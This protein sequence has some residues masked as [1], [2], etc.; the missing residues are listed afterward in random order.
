MIQ[1]HL[2]REKTIELGSFY[3]PGSLVN[4]AY[5]MLESKEAIKRDTIILDTSCGYGDFFL[6]NKGYRY[7]GSDID[8]QAL[9]KIGYGIKTFHRNALTNVCRSSYGIRE[10]DDLIIIGNPPYNDKSS[11]VG[12]G[13]KGKIYGVDDDLK[14]RD[15][16]ISF[17]RSYE[18]LSPSYVC[19][20]H[21]LSYLIKESNFKALKKFK[22][23]YTLIDGLICSSQLFDTKAVSFFPIII[24][25]Y[26]PSSCGMDYE[27]IRNYEFKT[28]EGNSLKLTD[29]DFIGNYVSK[30]P[31]KNND[32]RAVAYFFPMRDIN[33]LKRN[34]TFVSKECSF[35]IAVSEDKLEYYYYVHHFKQF[36]KRLP[37]YFGN[38][39]V[40]IDNDEFL[41]VCE[42]FKNERTN[43]TIDKYFENLFVKYVKN[44]STRTSSFLAIRSKKT[45]FAFALCAFIIGIACG[46]AYHKITGSNA[47]E[48]NA[49]N[50]TDELFIMLQTQKD[51]L[52]KIDNFRKITDRDRH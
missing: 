33:A 40:F 3:T 42:D 38:L 28:M 5:S 48:V 49:R 35:K 10:S 36:A 30:Y 37:Y 18:K 22:D 20:L 24:A 44:R 2:T 46:A 7:I 41:K 14:H 34:K 25:L 51:L 50:I 1:N 6:E 27:F 29:F 31:A 17:L 26:E 45:L 39:D 15:L 11:L 52:D 19:V 21:P 13:I 16:G 8:E 23:S 47:R 32:D 4:I 9:S 12:K 43:E